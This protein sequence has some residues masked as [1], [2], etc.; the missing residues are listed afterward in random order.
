MRLIIATLYHYADCRV[1]FIAMVNV[2]ILSAIM[3]NVIILSAVMLNVAEPKLKIKSTLI[4]KEISG[5]F[6]LN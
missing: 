6:N 5:N 2:I 4:Y 3:L 1:W